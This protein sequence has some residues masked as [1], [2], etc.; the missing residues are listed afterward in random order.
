MTFS[1]ITQY[2]PLSQEIS[3]RHKSITKTSFELFS[4]VNTSQ[5]QQNLISLNFSILK[6]SY[7]Q[8]ILVHFACKMGIFETKSEEDK[9]NIK[10]FH[11]QLLPGIYNHREAQEQLGK[12]QAKSNIPHTNE[13]NLFKESHNASSFHGYLFTSKKSN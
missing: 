10:I 7:L 11:F 3:Q 9:G 12:N 13:D 8:V 1:M 2:Q 4:I 5:S 6:K